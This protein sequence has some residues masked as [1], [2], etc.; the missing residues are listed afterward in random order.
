MEM[1]GHSKKSSSHVSTKKSVVP[2]KLRNEKDIAMDFAEKVQ[3]KFDRIVKSSVLFGS[4]AT[5]KNS[6]TADSDI[7]IIL[8]IDDAAIEWDMELVAWY[9][10]ELGKLIASQEYSKEIHINTV[11]LTTWW[12]DL[13]HGDPVVIN[14][15]RYGEALIDYG[16]FFNPLK[17]LLLKGKVK[18]TPEAVYAALRRA[19]GHIARSKI[20]EM[21][22]IEGVYWAMI[23][24]AQAALMMAGKMPPS[25]EH[26]PEMLKETF[27]D[28]GMLKSSQ[29]KSI[30]EIYVLHKSIS[31][32]QIGDIKGQEIDEW[33]D[34][35]EKFLSEM[36]RIIDI[37]IER[38]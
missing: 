10:E 24:S 35:A 28:A 13:L 23:D 15:L 12:E 29:V 4:H 30:R 18:S 36:T 14:I 2:R 17:A 6:A 34:I 31:H 27:V 9:R 5:G 7:D 21:S 20:S 16:G 26:I 37:L 8:I 33:Q 19:P 1:K 11:R 3:E 32:R 22:A 25:P 38:K